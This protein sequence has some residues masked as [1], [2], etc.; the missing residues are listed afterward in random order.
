MI[1]KLIILSKYDGDG[2]PGIVA[3]AELWHLLFGQL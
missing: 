3:N 1:L 2:A